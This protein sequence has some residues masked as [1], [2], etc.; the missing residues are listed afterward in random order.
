[1]V[2]DVG[3]CIFTNGASPTFCRVSIRGCVWLQ[4]CNALDCSCNFSPL[5]TVQCVLQCAVCSWAAAAQLQRRLCIKM[6]T[7]LLACCYCCCC[8]MFA[9]P[10]ARHHSVMQIATQC[11]ELR[12]VQWLCRAVFTFPHC[13]LCRAVLTCVTF[14]QCAVQSS[15]SQH[16]YVW[17]QSAATL[18]IGSTLP[19]SINQK[20]GAADKYGAGGLFSV[21]LP[22]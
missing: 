11:S 9:P 10:F 7:A 16:Q 2:G 18:H 15:A 8:T 4:G 14:A 19:S 5:C 12:C 17:Q 13:A 22:F 20:Y 21:S 6:Q 1:M 3:W